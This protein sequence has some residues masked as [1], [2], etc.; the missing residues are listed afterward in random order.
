MNYGYMDGRR[1]TDNSL[2]GCNA[3]GVVYIV[4]FTDRPKLQKIA[5]K[6]SFVLQGEC[7]SQARTDGEH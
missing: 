4:H 1:E 3:V 7:A 5:H 6:V 2:V